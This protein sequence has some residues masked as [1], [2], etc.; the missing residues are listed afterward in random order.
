MMKTS[1]FALA[2]GIAYLAAGVLGLIPAT[3]MPP[4]V[5]APPTTF[6]LLY[7]YFLGLFPVNLLHTMIHLAIGVWGIAA[8]AGSANSTTF[9]RALTVVFGLFAVMGMLPDL[10]TMFGLMPLQGHDIWLHGLTAA[11]AAYFGWRA[12]VLERDRRLMVNDRRQRMLPVARERRFGLADR[13]EDFAG[14]AP[15]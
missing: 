13:R 12:P 6:T 10:N 14:M 7:G 15:A 5:D 9:A 2:I 3:L 4:P 11:A 1:T 8:W